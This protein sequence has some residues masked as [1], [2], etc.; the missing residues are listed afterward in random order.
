MATTNYLSAISMTMIIFFASY[1]STDPDMLQDVC[2]ADF[3]NGN[4]NSYNDF[5]F[6]TL[7]LSIYRYV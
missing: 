4:L 3:T 7:Y 2:A 1:V 5:I 6:N